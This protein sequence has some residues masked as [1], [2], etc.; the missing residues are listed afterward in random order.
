MAIS[1]HICIAIRSR[2]E[3]Q[4]LEKYLNANNTNTLK[5]QNTKYKYKYLYWGCILN[6]NANTAKVI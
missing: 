3:V 6:T 2:V 5:L 4:Y 1:L